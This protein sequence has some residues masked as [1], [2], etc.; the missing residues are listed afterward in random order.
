MPPVH[1]AVSVADWPES[2]A[3][4]PTEQLSAEATLSVAPVGVVLVGVVAESVTVTATDELF[5]DVVT[6]FSVSVG[7]SVPAALP[8]TVHA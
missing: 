7:L 1:V 6:P 2:I 4:L 3:T 5:C 8:F